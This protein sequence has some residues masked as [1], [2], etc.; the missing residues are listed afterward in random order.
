MADIALEIP[1]TEFDIGRFR[2]RD[3]TAMARVQVL[4]DAFDRTSLAGGIAPFEE[5]QYPVARFLQPVVGLHQFGLQGCEVFLVMLALELLFVGIARALERIVL[6]PVRKVRIVEVECSRLSRNVQF[7]NGGVGNF[8]RQ[9]IFSSDCHFVTARLFLNGR[10]GK[11][12]PDGIF[13]RYGNF[14]PQ[15][16]TMPGRGLPEK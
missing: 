12:P 16:E 7:D 6:Y 3:P 8:H 10:E 15:T 11:S 13:C 5:R 4:A 14:W 1:L 9:L 2:K